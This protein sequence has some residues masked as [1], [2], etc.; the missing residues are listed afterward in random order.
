MRIF[1]HQFYYQ[2]QHLIL[3][4]ALHLFGLESLLDI[5]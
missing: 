2:P 3:C 5:T 1:A 4:V